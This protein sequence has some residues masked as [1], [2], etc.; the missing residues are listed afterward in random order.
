MRITAKD[1]CD[2]LLDPDA[3]DYDPASWTEFFETR[4]MTLD[5]IEE[6]YG[7]KQAERLTLL[8]R[9]ATLMGVIRLSMKKHVLV[10]SI[11]TKN[12]SQAMTSTGKF[13][14]YG[15]SKDNIK[16]CRAAIIMLTH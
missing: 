5:E 15:L 14:P 11:H 3:K 9:T 16:R 13:G 2:I 10:M 12:I 6:L 8:L 7:K 1:P 4:W